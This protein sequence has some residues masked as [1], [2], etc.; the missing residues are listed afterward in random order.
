SPPAR[1]VA[2]GGEELDPFLS[3]LHTATLDEGKRPRIEFP[4]R[5]SPAATIDYSQEPVAKDLAP[6]SLTAVTGY[7]PGG[8]ITVGH[9]NMML[10]RSEEH[11]SE[12]QSREN[13]VCR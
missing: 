7:E 9:E 13:L 1:Q 11:T 6:E 3:A 2:N 4:R 5:V 12:L 8:E 10:N